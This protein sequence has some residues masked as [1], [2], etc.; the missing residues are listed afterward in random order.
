MNS[1]RFIWLG[2]EWPVAVPKTMEAFLMS[3]TC[4]WLGDGA[5]LSRN[6]GI[7]PRGDA[8]G[9]AIAGTREA[10]TFLGSRIGVP[11]YWTVKIR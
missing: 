2:H 4:H 3:V 10:E 5:S 9:A 8:T 7:Q 11:A 1:A 6:F